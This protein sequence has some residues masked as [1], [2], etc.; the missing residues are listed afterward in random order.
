MSGQRDV[1]QPTRGANRCRRILIVDSSSAGPALP[2]VRYYSIEAT[3]SGMCKFE[4]EDSPG[5]LNIS[6]AIRE[7]VAKAPE[8]V[9]SRWEAED[10]ERRIRAAAENREPKAIY[11]RIPKMPCHLVI[12]PLL[13]VSRNPRLARLQN[14]REL[15][16]CPCPY[17]GLL[18]GRRT[19]AV[20][21]ST[22]ADCDLYS[23]D[24]ILIYTVI[25][26]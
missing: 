23:R 4:S 3:H 8:V 11:V 15:V 22:L 25:C 6:T 2:N 10:L 9:P 18:S 26:S 21:H 19:R 7:W 12:D 16:G 14:S 1:S 20:P 24:T 5:Y 13:T 17:L